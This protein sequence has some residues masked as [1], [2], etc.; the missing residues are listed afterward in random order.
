MKFDRDFLTDAFHRISI[1]VYQAGGFRGENAQDYICMYIWH[2]NARE[3]STQ[4]S[5][6]INYF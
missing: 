6:T 4:T 2:Y 1:P 3:T 5:V